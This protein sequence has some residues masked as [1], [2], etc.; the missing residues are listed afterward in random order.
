[1]ISSI[2]RFLL[3]IVLRIDS[4]TL[5]DIPR[6]G[7]YLILPN[8]INFIDAP[9]YYFYLRKIIP[10]I[11]VGKKELFDAPII[12]RMLK[13]WEALPVDR[14]GFDR[15]FM[16]KASDYLAQNKILGIAPEGT[17]SETGKLGQGKDGII[18]IALKCNVPMLPIVHI[19]T[20]ELG[21]NLKR[22]RRTNITLKKGPMF[23]IAD[24]VNFSNK[25]QRKQISWEIM[26]RIAEL[27]PVK[28][29]GYYEGNICSEYKLTYNV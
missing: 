12:G 3:R 9:L 13:N 21:R 19:G 23:R 28:Y 17:R 22:F 8:H 4:K 6:T 10:I 2:V 5:E 18:Y 20:E 16:K 26:S 1:L 11:G 27:L 29:H 25:E 15:N 7:P 14:K 24:D